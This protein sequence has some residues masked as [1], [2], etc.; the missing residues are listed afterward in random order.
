[1]TKAWKKMIRLA[2]LAGDRSEAREHDREGRG[3]TVGASHDPLALNRVDGLDPDREW[4]LTFDTI[5]D[6]LLILDP[7]LTIVR[8]NAAARRLLLPDGQEELAGRK[9][10]EVFAGNTQPCALCPTG[11]SCEQGRVREQ[12]IEHRFLG[13]IFLVS[14]TPMYD[15]G[16]LAGYVHFARDMT[17][18]RMLEKQLVQAQKME[19]IATLAG[20][21][22]HDFNNILGAILGNADLL[23]YRLPGGRASDRGQEPPPPAE[24]VEHVKAIKKAG[25]RAKEL[26][27]QILSF[28]RQNMGER[29]EVDISPVVK[30]GFKLLRSSLPATIEMALKIDPDLGVIRADP[31]QIHQALVNLVTNAAQAIGDGIGR[32][33]VRLRNLEVDEE[34]CRRCHDLV[35]GSYVALEVADTGHGIPEPL[36]SRIFDPFFT[37]REVGEGAGMGLAVTHGIVTASEGVIDVRSSDGGTVFTLYFPRVHQAQPARIDA[38]TDLQRGSETVLFVDDEEDIVKM[39]GRMLEYLGYTVLS[40]HSGPEALEIFHRDPAA[41]DLVITDQTMPEMTGLALARVING[42]RPDLPIILCSGYSDAVTPEEAM[43]AG[44]RRFLAKPLD[45][46]HLARTMRELLTRET[47]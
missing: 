36:L 34:T 37:T 47:P 11:K 8:A 43:A 14:C 2:R 32:I 21:I 29:Q 3:D 46:R 16:R 10:H 18:Q 41:I 6:P 35:P 27:G 22:A 45:M 20:G 38:V 23:L 1:M 17:R 44:I 30:E 19:A 7:D 9:C 12:I 40:A 25:L 39:R 33:E 42:E 5:T 15:S 4:R 31:T 13:R 28:S 26:V 24:I